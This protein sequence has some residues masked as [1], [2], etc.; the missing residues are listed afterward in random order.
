MDGRRTTANNALP[1][2]SQAREHRQPKDPMKRPTL[3][4][5]LARCALLAALAAATGHASAQAAYPS[6]PIRLLVPYGAGGVADITARIVS[7]KVAAS[8]GQAIVVENRPGAGSVV[9]ASTVAR[10]EPD[11]HTLLLI[12]NSSALAPMLFKSLPYDVINDFVYISSFSFFDIALVVDKDSPFNSVRDLLAFARANPGKVNI[13]TIS[14]GTTQN[15]A[16]ELF[17]STGKIAIQTV[18][19]KSSAEVLSAIKS[20]DVQ[21]AFE[22]VAPIMG[23]IASG[24]LKVLGVASSKRSV[25]LPNAPTIASALPG[26]TASSWNGVAAPARTPAAIVARLHREIEKALDD[27]EVKQKFIAL[28][29]EPRSSTPEQTRAQIEADMLKWK[30]VIELARIERQ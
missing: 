10:A 13:G 20:G 1:C 28:G 14:V 3:L 26:F 6:K 8:L 24:H 16:S 11:G 15:L 23:Q 4:M 25:A 2:R 18:P 5:R 9:A 19:Y 21:A 17:K 30:S 27:P 29:V 12:G 7:Q 22:I